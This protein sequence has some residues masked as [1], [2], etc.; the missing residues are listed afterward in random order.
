L[1]SCNPIAAARPAPITKHAA[2]PTYFRPATEP[3]SRP[4]YCCL[5]GPFVACVSAEPPEGAPYGSLH[6]HPAPKQSRETATIFSQ[7]L[8]TPW[9]VMCSK[10]YP[11]HCCLAACYPW[12]GHPDA[13]RPAATKLSAVRL[14]KEI[15]ARRVIWWRWA[16]ICYDSCQTTTT[17]RTMDANSYGHQSITKRAHIEHQTR[18][19]ADSFCNR[20][21]SHHARIEES[22]DVASAPRPRGVV[23][24]IAEGVYHMTAALKVVRQ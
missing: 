3:R 5:V 20:R 11:A 17:A 23:K 7:L 19:E 21:E 6:S 15:L 10:R 18:G 4:E 22:C 13:T 12:T 9:T 24:E 8:P 2:S 16:D 1:F 14:T